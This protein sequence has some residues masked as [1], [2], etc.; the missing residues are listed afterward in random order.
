[1]NGTTLIGGGSVSP[2]PG[3]AWKAIGTGD[4]DDDGDSDILC[5][6]T[7][8]GQISIWEMKGTSLLGGG[9]VS[10]NPGTSWQA[11]GT[12]DFNQDGHSDIL[13]Q[14]KSTGQVSV[15]EMN[16]NALIGGGPVA[17][18]GTS[19]H[20]IGTGANGADILL[21]NTSG[22]ATHNCERS[23]EAIQRTWTPYVPL[24]C[25][26]IGRPKGPASLDAL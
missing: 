17:N 10:I 2:N 5:Q 7:S 11:I 22:Q 3:P 19:W 26:A 15:W 12:G 20:P 6:N 1:M 8:T 13:L 9:P 4:L 23:D 25:L 16:G 14:N 18:P 21:Q 24:D